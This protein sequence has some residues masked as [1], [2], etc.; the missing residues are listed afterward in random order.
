M[1]RRDADHLAKTVV[2]IADKLQHSSFLNPEADMAEAADGRQSTIATEIQDCSNAT[3]ESADCSA[4][5]SV[6]PAG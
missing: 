3:S 5:S 4:D 2:V 1:R 6:G